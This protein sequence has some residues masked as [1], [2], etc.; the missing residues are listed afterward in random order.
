VELPFNINL[1]TNSKT[2]FYITDVTI[3][4]SF[5]TIEA[6]RNDMIYFIIIANSEFEDHLMC[7]KRIPEGNYSLVT[8]NNAIANIMNTGYLSPINTV[9][10]N[11][12]ISTP[13]ISKNKILIGNNDNSFEILTDEQVLGHIYN[14]WEEASYPLHSINAM[15][16]NFTPNHIERG[17]D[18]YM[19]GYVDL[20][21]IRNLYITS[22]ALGNFSSISLNGERGVLKKVPLRAS[23]GELLFDQTVLGMDYLDCSHQSLSRLDFKLKDSYGNTI[24]LNGNHWSF[25]IVFVKLNEE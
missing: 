23:Y 13:S 12:F 24:N 2:G 10:P 7:A 11:K 16:Q 18:F 14:G 1:P 8:L 21:P 15:I 22:Q 20:F 3:P 4:I 25:S 17:V 5:Y 9:I 6:G 19:S